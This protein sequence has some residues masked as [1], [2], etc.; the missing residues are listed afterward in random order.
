VAAIPLF[1]EEFRTQFPWFAKGWAKESAQNKQIITNTLQKQL[2][3]L[4]HPDSKPPPRES[5]STATFSLNF[6]RPSVPISSPL[7][8]LSVDIFFFFSLFF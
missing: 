4:I 7:A 3:H 1:V 8:I 2:Q 5:I 6:R